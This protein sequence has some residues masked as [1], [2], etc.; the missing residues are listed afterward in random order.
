MKTTKD[1]ILMASLKLFAESGYDAVSTSM[2]A[3]ELGITKGA[4][5]RHFAN[6]QEIFDSIIKKMFELDAERANED[7]VPQKEYSQDPESYKNTGLD[8]FC[9]FV[10]NQFDFWTGDEFASCFRK[11]LTIEQF[12]TPEMQ[13]LYQ[14][15]IAIGPVRY[16]ADLFAE[17]LA[18]GKLNDEAKKFGAW[19]LALQFF[20]P[21]QL[22]IQLSDGGEDKNK[23][24]DQLRQITEE[25]ERRW[26]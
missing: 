17:M 12:K 18:S 21:L 4:L 10:Q 9:E 26:C 1:Q 22:L 19:N 2:I 20:A 16:S 15:V 24:R 8:D 6:K 23:L 14:D 3:A 25:F 5:Y 7:K 11:M 13:K